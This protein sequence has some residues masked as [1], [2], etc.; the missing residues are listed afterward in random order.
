MWLIILVPLAFVLVFLAAPLWIPMLTKLSGPAM[1]ESLEERVDRRKKKVEILE[2]SKPVRSVFAGLF[3]I[4]LASYG[5][6][7]GNMYLF[8]AR[9]VDVVQKSEDPDG[10]AF[11]V[12]IVLSIGLFSLLYG[13][14]KM[15]KQK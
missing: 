8:G 5:L 15:R 3:L 2:R 9:G 6:Y 4:G 1:E 7:D 14:S 13:L 10:F 11:F 12:V